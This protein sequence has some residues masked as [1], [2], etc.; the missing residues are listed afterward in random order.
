M[1]VSP[2]GVEH[3]DVV[4]SKGFGGMA[5]ATM[6]SAASGA[7]KAKSF[8]AKLKPMANNFATKAKPMANNFATKTKPMVAAAPV[9]ARNFAIKNKKSIGIGAAVGAGGAA[10]G[11]AV[12]RAGSRNR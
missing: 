4:V 6:F 8:G 2:F 7:N 11:Y 9:Q 10:G 3:S 1:Y 5:G 12:S